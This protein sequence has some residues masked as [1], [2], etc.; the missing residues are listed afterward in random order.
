MKDEEL[1]DLKLFCKDFKRFEIVDD[2]DEDS[3]EDCAEDYTVHTLV[4]TRIMYVVSAN[5]MEEAKEEQRQQR[6]YYSII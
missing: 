6:N 4:T 2:E 5:S 3:D 1:N